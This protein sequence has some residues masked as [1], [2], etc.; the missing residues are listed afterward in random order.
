V[1]PLDD[2][3]R[4]LPRRFT[5]RRDI[6]TVC[7]KLSDLR[8]REVLPAPF[9]S[10]QHPLISCSV[11]GF[12]VRTEERDFIGYPVDAPDLY[13]TVV[14]LHE[15]CHWA[16]NHRGQPLNRARLIQA[17]APTLHLLGGETIEEILGR[18]D[19]DD[20]IE[21]EAEEFAY[22]VAGLPLLG[23]NRIDPDIPQVLQNVR[24]AIAD[25]FGSV[26]GRRRV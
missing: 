4:L 11:T 15:V 8:D 25:P 20:E 10:R 14:F 2:I 17:A 3:V 19:A 6:P 23:V 16:R 13:I 1:V 9:D 26:R 18:T 22:S 7:E 24:G 5:P 12:C 21:Q